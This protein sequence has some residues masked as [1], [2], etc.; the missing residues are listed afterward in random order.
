V[1]GDDETES[2]V[3]VLTYHDLFVVVV[4]EGNG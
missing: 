2:A 4:D 1:H 3:R